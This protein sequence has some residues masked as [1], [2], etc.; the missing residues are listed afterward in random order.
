[1]VRLVTLGKQMIHSLRIALS[2]IAFIA[3]TGCFTFPAPGG[4][5]R[6][7]SLAQEVCAECHA[8]E[9]GQSPSPNGDAPT[10]EDV[11]NNPGMTPLALQMLLQAPHRTMPNILF[12]RTE[13]MDVSA[14][15]LSLE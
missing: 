7:L 10:F 14:Y 11:A 13:I 15:I 2:G 6:G 1:V 8:V 12:E 3:L 4:A 5:L 9:K